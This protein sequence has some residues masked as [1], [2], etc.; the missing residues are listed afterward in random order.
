VLLDQQNRED[1][2]V[3]TTTGSPVVTGTW[4]S[5]PTHSAVGFRVLYM[6]IAPFEGAF[7]EF[8]A[9]LDGDGLRGVADASSI[10][11]DNEQLAQHL[12]SPDFFDTANHAQLRFEGGPLEARAD[13]SVAVEGTLVVKGESAPVTLTGRLTEPVTDP[14]GATKRGLT[15][16]GLVDRTEL[17]LDWNAPLPEGGKMLADEVELT[18]SLLFVAEEA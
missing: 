6:G 4:I 17:G 8:A 9:T 14:Y 3:S 11:V 5:D 18:A 2:D 12:A 13:G 15:L 10:D 1:I 16:T 7:R